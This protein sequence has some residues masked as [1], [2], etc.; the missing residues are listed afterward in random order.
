[1]IRLFPRALQPL[2]LVDF[3]GDGQS[4]WCEVLPDCSF[5]LHFSN[6]E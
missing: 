2:F 1:M 4:E 6:N 3:F 5:T